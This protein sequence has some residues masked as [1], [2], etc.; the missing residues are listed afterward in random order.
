MTA[1]TTNR[2][3]VYGT[4]KRNG[5]NHWLLIGASFRGETATRQRFR[6]IS[7]SF[8]VILDKKDGWPVHG[9][10]YHVNDETL[11]SLDRLERVGRL[12]DRKIADVIENDREVKAHIYVGRLEYWKHSDMP[13]WH[14]TNSNGELDWKQPTLLASPKHPRSERPCA[15]R[16]G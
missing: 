16:F 5:S 12:Y 8:P 15:T 2:V 10:I 4:L 1:P 9:E 14:Q 11:A 7:A 3:F 6:M 13:P